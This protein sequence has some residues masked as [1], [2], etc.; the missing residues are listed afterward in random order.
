MKQALSAGATALFAMVCALPAQRHRNRQENPALLGVVTVAVKEGVRVAHVLPDSP[1]AA[2]GFAAGDLLLEVGVAK[3]EAPTDVDDELRKVQPDE[4][5]A[6]R[7]RRPSDKD[8]TLIAKLI[9]REAYE[10]EF[11]QPRATGSVGFAAPDW[12]GYAWSGVSATRPAPTPANTQDKVV[13]FHA[14]QSW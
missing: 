2:A 8:R 5:V 1:A 12:W 14:F 3:I 13:V 10:G 4:K 7:V 6:I 11:L 9:A